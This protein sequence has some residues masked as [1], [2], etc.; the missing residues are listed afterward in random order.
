[1]SQATLIV[2]QG[3]HKNT[4]WFQVVIKSKLTGI[5]L[6]NWWLQLHKLIQFH[7]VSHTLNVP[8]SCYLFLELIYMQ[9]HIYINIPISF[10]FITTWNQGVFLCSPC[11]IILLL[12]IF[13]KNHQCLVMNNLKYSSDVLITLQ[14]NWHTSGIQ[15]NVFWILKFL[16]TTKRFDHKECQKTIIGLNLKS[17]CLTIFTG[18]WVWNL[19]KHVNFN[20]ILLSL[21]F[22]VNNY[23]FVV[24]WQQ[25]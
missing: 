8:P 2:I 16:Y 5:F 22:S 20:F 25:F 12:V 10:D 11:I 24:S 6:Q 18:N 3:E 7:V 9:S 13:H 17:S 23:L 19:G 4:P 21:L 15:C 14:R 1:M